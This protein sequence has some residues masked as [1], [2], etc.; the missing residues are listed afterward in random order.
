MQTQTEKTD[1]IY[2]YDSVHAYLNSIKDKHPGTGK[3]ITLQAWSNRLGYKSPRLI[4][5]VIKEIPVQAIKR[6]S[7]FAFFFGDFVMTGFTVVP[8][9]VD[10][11]T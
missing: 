7:I 9:F 11:T 8:P 10:V 6:T 3:S 4:S 5:M 2:A 1:S